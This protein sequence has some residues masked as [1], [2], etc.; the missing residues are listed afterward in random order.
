MQINTTA[1]GL[2]D[3]Q[4][5]RTAQQSHKVLKM[6]RNERMAGSIPSWQPARTQQERIA[7]DINN[8]VQNTGQTQ[9]FENALALQTN[10]SAPQAQSQ[11]EFG[12][13]DLLDMINPLHHIPI[14]GTVYRELSGDQIRPVSRLIGGGVFGGVAGVASGLVNIIAE[15]ETGRDL[16]ENALHLVAG[17]ESDNDKLEQALSG[18]TPEK[19]LEQAIRDINNGDSALPASMLA[20]TDQTIGRAPVKNPS[21]QQKVPFR[22]L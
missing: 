8:A 11:Q 10:P 5:Q 6:V 9:S 21:T 4:A 19:A 7:A 15:E 3:L 22:E 13:G 14:L 2:I 20:F 1:T 16:T 17:G 18:D 12:F